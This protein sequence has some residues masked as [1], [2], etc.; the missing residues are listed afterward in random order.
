MFAPVPQLFLPRALIFAAL[1]AIIP[2]M[3][4]F[5]ITLPLVTEAGATAFPVSDFA[6][7]TGAVAHP[8]R[9]ASH[10]PQFSTA[11]WTRE[12]GSD[13]TVYAISYAG[14]AET[15]YPGHHSICVAPRLIN[16]EAGG[17]GLIKDGGKTY[18]SH[19]GDLVY[20]P[21]TVEDNQEVL[22]SIN[23]N[24]DTIAAYI[25]SDNAPSKDGCDDNYDVPIVRRNNN[26]VVHGDGKVY[27]RVNTPRP[28]FGVASRYY[29]GA[30]FSNGEKCKVSESHSY[31]FRCEPI[32]A[33]RAADNIQI[34]TGLVAAQFEPCN[35]FNKLKATTCQE[36]DTDRFAIGEFLNNDLLAG[37]I[38]L[39]ELINN[40]KSVNFERKLRRI[41][42]GGRV[43]I[44]C[45]GRVG[46]AKRVDAEH[47][48]V[49]LDVG[50][51]ALV[52]R[53]EDLE[54]AK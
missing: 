41:E 9:A 10:S 32:A 7:A 13:L 3:G 29:D 24:E 12:A 44:K 21:Q 15:N 4:E 31:M 53:S 48:L 50:G 22:N 25:T 2:A 8:N 34:A 14:R 19:G 47:G 46:I 11:I 40:P 18:L 16:P 28:H 36:L 6:I 5:K 52:Y 37:A 54:A 26:C 43:K 20:Y 1:Y 45:E 39:S 42:V 35:K 30:L 17:F 38:R 51:R 49:T 23:P 33:H 27:C